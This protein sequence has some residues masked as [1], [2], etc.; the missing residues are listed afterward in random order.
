MAFMVLVPNQ[1]L[2]LSWIL[3]TFLLPCPHRA[4]CHQRALPPIA[5]GL[6]QFLLR[7]AVTVLS[8]WVLLF[9]CLGH[10]NNTC[11]TDLTSFMF[12]TSLEICQSHFGVLLPLS[13]SG[14]GVSACLFRIHTHSCSLYS[15]PL[16]LPGVLGT[17]KDIS[18]T[19][20]C[21]I[22]RDIVFVFFIL[23]NIWIAFPVSCL[24]LKGNFQQLQSYTDWFRARICVSLCPP[25]AILATRKPGCY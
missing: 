6:R 17:R 12:W 14:G 18:N 25:G 13:G 9:W 21:V 23:S 5:D 2:N 11:G 20:S 22:P 4:N 16:S 8:L 7:L 3:Q 24:P 10:V 19:G 15:K 1:L